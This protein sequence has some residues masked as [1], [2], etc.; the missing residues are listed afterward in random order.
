V[1][2]IPGLSPDVL[3]GADLF[4]LLAVDID[5]EGGIAFSTPGAVPMANPPSARLSPLGDGTMSLPIEVEGVQT[6]ALLDLG[7]SASPLSVTDRFYTRLGLPDGRPK[8]LV[9]RS[10]ILGYS[11]E[12][13]FSFKSAKVGGHTISDVPADMFKFPGGAHPDVNLGAE[14]LS[15]FAVRLDFPASGIW[16]EN[17]L[18]S[19]PSFTRDHVGLELKRAGLEAE[20]TFVRPGSPADTH[21]WKPGERFSH[22]NDRSVGDRA[23]GALWDNQVAIDRPS[24]EVT[25]RMSNGAIKRLKSARYY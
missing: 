25:F 5:F 16:L 20:V 8:T 18:D 11:K 6:R 13:M 19:I 3:L 17:R 7:N 9:T 10:G 14:F 2:V 23:S 24:E 1:L 12:E 4:E 15:K 22:V 21:G